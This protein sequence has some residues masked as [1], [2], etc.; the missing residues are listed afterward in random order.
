MLQ[1]AR[2][3]SNGVGPSRAGVGGYWAAAM[4]AGSG[5][6]V[7]NVR[8]LQRGVPDR[9][10]ESRRPRDSGGVVAAA[11]LVAVGVVAMAQPVWRGCGRGGSM[12]A[13]RRARGGRLRAGAGMDR[14]ATAAVAWRRREGPGKREAPSPP[15]WVAVGRA[16]ARVCSCPLRA[17]G[18]ATHARA[19]P[20]H[21]VETG[22]S[23]WKTARRLGSA[24]PLPVASSVLASV[25]LV[26]SSERPARAEA[27]CS[28]FWGRPGVSQGPEEVLG[29]AV[30]NLD[31]CPDRVLFE[32]DLG[33]ESPQTWHS[34]PDLGTGKG[35]A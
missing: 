16:W 26:G 20:R 5:R 27:S 22:A 24:S 34:A 13:A 33:C 12:P 7:V 3:E 32:V 19:V 8:P 28:D 18:V 9:R 2:A 10:G 35:L 6:P 30:A 25:V 23:L 15:A 29:G 11:V 14:L 21:C 17:C 4:W 1:G 31:R